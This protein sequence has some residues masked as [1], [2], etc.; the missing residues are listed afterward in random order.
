MSDLPITGNAARWPHLESCYALARAAAAGFAP[1][2]CADPAFTAARWGLHLGLALAR[3]DPEFAQSVG[4]E[5]DDYDLARDG[6]E[7]MTWARF[8]MTRDVTRLRR[9][10]ARFAGGQPGE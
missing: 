5:L 6:I 4:D 1:G 9:A 2:A 3:L 10:A 7:A 8:D